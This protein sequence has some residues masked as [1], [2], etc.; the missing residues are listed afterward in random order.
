M[1]SVH[2][3]FRN[4][5]ELQADGTWL[6]KFTVVDDRGI[7]ESQRT[8]STMYELMYHVPAMLDANKRLGRMAARNLEQRDL[9]T[10]RAIKLAEKAAIK[11][12]KLSK[13]FLEDERVRGDDKEEAKVPI[14]KRVKFTD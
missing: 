11:T 12:V 5:F 14:A 4:I 2:D 1:Q 3:M 8:F 13:G 7:R 10:K 6:A 9:A